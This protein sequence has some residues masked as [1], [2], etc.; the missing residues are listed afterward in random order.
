MAKMSTYA[1]VYPDAA[2]LWRFRIRS[3]NHRIVGIGEG[4]TRYA[5]AKRGARRVSGGI[6]VFKA[7]KVNQKAKDFSQDWR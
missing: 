5:D 6:P 3:A 1:Q 4:Y 2:G 7:S